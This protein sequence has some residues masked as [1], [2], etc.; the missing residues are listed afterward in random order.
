MS[1]IISIKN[2]RKSFFNQGQK[3]EVLKGI[4][5]NFESGKIIGYIG[6]NG[7]GKSTTVKIL[8]GIIEDYEG[9]V[10]IFGKS[11]DGNSLELKRKIGYIPENDAL[12][13]TLTPR[14]FLD[15]IAGLYDIEGKEAEEKISSFLDFFEMKSEAD[16]RMNTFSKGM[17][18]KIKIIS[19]LL[20]SPDIIFMDEPLSGLD[21]NSV[22]LVKELINSL[23]A[24]GKTIFY[25]SHIMD[26]VENMSDEIVMLND[27]HIIAQGKCKELMAKEDVDSLEALFAKLTGNT[28]QKEK[29]ANFIKS[30]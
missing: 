30:F 29:T 27:G 2:L 11:L 19:G 7:A 1:D 4:D 9:E 28:E 26:V 13:D 17:K 18:Q 16:K 3:K 8:C 10:D 20:H 21:A 22:I 23:V 6:P 5:L 12:Y 14:E 24:Q 25:C 15:F